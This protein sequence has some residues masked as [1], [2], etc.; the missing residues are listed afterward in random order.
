MRGAAASLIYFIVDAFRSIRENL[1]T[2]LLTTLTLGFSLTI[3]TVFFIV[4]LN[5]NT[6]VY[7]LGNRVHMV[8]YIRDTAAGTGVPALKE[9]AGKVPG[10]KSVDYVSKERALQEMKEELK[11]HEGILEGI[12]ASSLPDSFEIML[13]E[14]SRT[15]E[16][17]EAV[18]G[19]FKRIDWVEDVQYS[20]Q[21]A[22]R[23]SSVIS[24]IELGVMTVGIFL[25]AAALFIITNT[26][27]LTIYA[28]KDE[29]EVLRLIGA[30]R[31]FIKA[32]FFIEGAAAGAAGGLVAPGIFFAGRLLLMSN[33]PTKLSFIVDV[34][35]PVTVLAA[36]TAAAGVF[37]GAAGSLISMTRFLKT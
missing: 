26:V 34:P 17:V 5:I 9:E 25:A 10:V 30:S 6:A 2:T 4:S 29:I 20:R 7:N 15:E 12:D 8:V 37:L 13:T 3:L 33:M 14:A 11:G 23:F 16:Q 24:F 22:R 27:R 1:A 35:V 32:P 18:A 28:R 19:V 21:W 36:V 31:I